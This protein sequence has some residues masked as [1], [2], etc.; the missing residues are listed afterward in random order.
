[1]LSTRM[2][3]SLARLA[4]ELPA[5]RREAMET[6]PPAGPPAESAAAPEGYLL[7]RPPADELP[8]DTR[9]LGARL[10]GAAVALTGRPDGLAVV[11][12]ET[13]GLA[14][15]PLFLVGVLS[16]GPGGARIDQHFARRPE[17]EKALLE[18]V[19]RQLCRFEGLVTF[20]GERFDLPF[21]DARMARH[22]LPRVLP[23]GH[24]DLLPPARTRWGLALPDCRLVTLE[25]R[26]LGRPR[27]EDVPGSA[28]PALYARFHRTGDWAAVTPILRHNALDLLATAELLPLLAIDR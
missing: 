11:D 10:A 20:N 6:D 28:V 15:V 16:L 12:L 7:V 27:Q 24:L 23:A 17:E 19:L 13:T 14:G 1:V 5:P 9:A 18:G 25:D 22:R 26:V 3:Q 4:R 8:V 21:L 2:R